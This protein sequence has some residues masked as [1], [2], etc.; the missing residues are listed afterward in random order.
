LQRFVARAAARAA[1]IAAW[2]FPSYGPPSK[3]QYVAVWPVGLRLRPLH[4]AQESRVVRLR[5]CICIC[6]YQ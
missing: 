2:K 3:A 5:L 6:K 1:V 4:M